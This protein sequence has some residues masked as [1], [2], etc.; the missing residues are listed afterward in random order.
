MVIPK[1]S[2]CI[3]T[4]NRGEFIGQTLESIVT[5]VSKEVEIIVVDGNSSDNTEIVISRYQEIYSNFRYY[6]ELTNSGVDEDYDKAVNYATG[7]YCWLM[8]DDDLLIESSINKILSIIEM[9][10]DLIIV[11]SEIWNADFTKDLQTK[12]LNASVDKIYRPSDENN[13]LGELSTCLSFIGSVIIKKNVWLDRDRSSYFGSLFIHVGVIFQMPIVGDVYVISDPVLKIRYG[14]GMWSPRSFEIW[15][16][17]WPELIWSFQR[18][19]DS[20][21][22]NVI[23]REPW[24]CNF[25][26]LKSKAMGDFSY[27]EFKKF[28]SKKNVSINYIMAYI[29]SILPPK[30]VNFILVFIYCI[31]KRSAKYTIFDL[32]RS[33]HS[34]L[35]CRSF[36]KTFKLNLV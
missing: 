2:I 10:Y 16:F 18:F 17:K 31:F 34:S 15:Y 21:K 8:T 6:R 26:L 22:R 7:E 20:A 23:R 33:K 12:M 13:L 29:I 24:K 1:L 27:N 25:G 3:A 36:A 9:K 5:Q 30:I 11:N 19:S 35:I 4:F 14:N 28:I 32:L